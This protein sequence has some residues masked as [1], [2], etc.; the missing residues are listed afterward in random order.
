MDG[1]NRILRLP[2]VINKVGLGR[3]AI[4]KL[5]KKN[6]FPAPVKLTSRS[7]GWA[8]NAI[9]KWISC[10]IEESNKKGNGGNNA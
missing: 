6:E 9:N 7:S 1:S 10:R 8:D 5:I 4:Y 3:G 2:E